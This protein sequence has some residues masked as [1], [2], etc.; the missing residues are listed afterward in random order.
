[1][2]QIKIFVRV[3]GVLFVYRSRQMLTCINGQWLALSWYYT[4]SVSLRS[5]ASR[6]AGLPR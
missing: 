4:D 6:G 3:S 2:C 1:M 5:S